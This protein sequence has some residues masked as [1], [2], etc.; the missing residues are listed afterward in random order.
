MFLL[1][2]FSLNL[3]AGEDTYISAELSF[4][5]DIVVQHFKYGEE[6]DVAGLMVI[7][8][9]VGSVKERN[10]HHWTRN[11]PGPTVEKLLNVIKG[12]PARYMLLG[13]KKYNCQDFAQNVLNKL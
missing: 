2:P 5:G 4:A 6:Q 7:C 12:E 10:G 9:Q 3:L 1:H 11:S 13:P 8:N